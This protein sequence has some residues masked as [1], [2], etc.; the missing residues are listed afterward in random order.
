MK[1]ALVARLVEEPVEVDIVAV[2]LDIAAV[3]VRAVEVLRQIEDDLQKSLHLNMREVV[4]QAF[5]QVSPLLL[6]CQ[7]PLLQMRT[8]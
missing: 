5:L 6:V 8:Q 2:P 1:I 4:R 3:V 7:E